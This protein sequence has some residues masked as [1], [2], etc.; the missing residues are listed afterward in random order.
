MEAA[1]I[2]NDGEVVSNFS[3]TNGNANFSDNES[4]IDDSSKFEEFVARYLS[5]YKRM[6]GSTITF[7]EIIEFL[8]SKDNGYFNDLVYRLIFE[9]KKEIVEWT[10]STTVESELSED[11]LAFYYDYIDAEERK[12]SLLK[13]ALT[14]ESVEEDSNTTVKNEM[15]LVPTPTGNIRIIED[16][17]H[18][19]PEYYPAFKELL[20][21]IEDGT[22]L[23]FKTLTKG[24]T[25]GLSEVKG[26]KIRVVFTRLKDNYYAILTA[27]VKKSDNDKMYRT[28]LENRYVN[29]KMHEDQLIKQLDN[30]EFLNENA[31]QVQELY[32]LLGVE[33]NKEYKRGGLNG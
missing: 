23:G 27:F 17:Q 28:N 2:T 1:S 7:D 32:R 5:E 8:P 11:D 15:I 29:F 25:S 18:I 13:K 14:Y 22:F 9:T 20:E 30:P 26:F 4:S 6:D 3:F 12:I 19:A 31:L 16:L 21:S 24:I 10:S 33:E